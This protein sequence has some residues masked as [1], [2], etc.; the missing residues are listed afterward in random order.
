MAVVPQIRFAARALVGLTLF[1]GVGLLAVMLTVA[2]VT[3][4]GGIARAGG[5]VSPLT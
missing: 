3:L 1:L 4:G 2:P 5:I